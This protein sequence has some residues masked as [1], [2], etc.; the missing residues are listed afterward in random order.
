MGRPEGRLFDQ[1][2][3]LVIPG[4]WIPVLSSF[5]AFKQAPGPQ[6]PA[7]SLAVGCPLGARRWVVAALHE[8]SLPLRPSCMHPSPANMPMVQH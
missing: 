7:V 3:S 8:H 2:R 6:G 5:G 4:Q 1:A